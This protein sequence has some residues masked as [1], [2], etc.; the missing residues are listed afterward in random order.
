[1]S[2]LHQIFRKPFLSARDHDLTLDHD[3]DFDHDLDHDL[4]LDLDLELDLTENNLF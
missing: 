3:L 4:D 2:D 1:M